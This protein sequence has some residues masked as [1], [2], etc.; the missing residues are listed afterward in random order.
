MNKN[1]GS[2][3]KSAVKGIA[4]ENPLRPSRIAKAMAAGRLLSNGS[5]K[6]EKPAKPIKVKSTRVD[7]SRD[8]TRRKEEPQDSGPINVKSERINVP[9][10]A[11]GRGP[12]ELPA[13]PTKKTSKPRKPRDVKYTQPTLPGMRNTRQFKGKSGKV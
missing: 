2:F 6:K 9:Q 10:E 7:D 1:E 13:P 4:S 8:D 11:I 12:R 5:A 3:S